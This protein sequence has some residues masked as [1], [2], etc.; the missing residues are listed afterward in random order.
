[1][2][3]VFLPG[4]IVEIL[5]RSIV[6]SALVFVVAFAYC[7]MDRLAGVTIKIEGKR[8][9]IFTCWAGVPG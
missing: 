6:V 3:V 2:W 1:M 4:M 9:G 7:R 5:A 8:V